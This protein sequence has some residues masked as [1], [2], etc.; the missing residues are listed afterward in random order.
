MLHITE[1]LKPF[2]RSRSRWESNRPIIID[3]KELAREG[4]LSADYAQ[5]FGLE[6]RKDYGSLMLSSLFRPGRHFDCV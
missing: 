6:E 4:F 3:R 5:L 1:V 2:G